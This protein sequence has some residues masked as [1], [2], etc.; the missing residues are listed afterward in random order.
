[1]PTTR[2]TIHDPLYRIEFTPDDRY[3]VRKTYFVGKIEFSPLLRGTYNTQ[4]DAAEAA[5]RDVN[6]NRTEEVE[7]QIQ[8]AE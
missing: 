4:D 2:P 3:C 8:Y 5:R 6:I 7:P 1:M